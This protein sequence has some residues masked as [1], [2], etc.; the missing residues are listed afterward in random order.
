MEEV[1][2]NTTIESALIKDWGN[3]PLEG[4]NKNC[5]HQDPGKRSSDPTETDPYL[6][7]SVQ[8]APLEVWVGN[9]LV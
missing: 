7:V 5:V 6:P 1:T 9:G 8:E 4:T 3:R 2:I